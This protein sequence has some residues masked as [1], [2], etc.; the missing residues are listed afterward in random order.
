[1]NQESSFQMVGR[2]SAA[3]EVLN[4]SYNRGGEGVLLRDCNDTVISFLRFICLFENDKGNERE[5][6]REIFLSPG[7]FSKCL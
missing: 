4:K 1:M 2:L 6:G 3:I 5:K 7:S